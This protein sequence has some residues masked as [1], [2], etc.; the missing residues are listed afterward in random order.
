LGSWKTYFN[1]EY[2]IQDNAIGTG[3][4]GDAAASLAKVFGKTD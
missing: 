4:A 3:N 2:T 1:P